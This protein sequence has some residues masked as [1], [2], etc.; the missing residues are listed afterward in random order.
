L[1]QLKIIRGQLFEEP[2]S[3]EAYFTT[4]YLR[5]RKAEG[6]I[7]S[8]CE[9]AELPHVPFA[10]PYSAEWKK[11]NYSCEK[12]LQYLVKHP[13]IRNILE[14]GCGNGWLTAKLSS[15]TKGSATGMDINRVELEQAKKV[16]GKL[17]GICFLEGDIRT[18]VLEEKRFDMIVFAASIQYFPSIKEIIESAL[19]HLT[20]MGEIHIIDS[21]F[22]RSTEL[23][24]AR[25]RSRNYFINRGIPEMINFYF[26]HNS[27]E[28]NCFDYQLL[29]N[30]D[31][32]LQKLKRN[33]S[34]F[35]WVVIKNYK[36]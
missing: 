10:H 33:K 18:G 35:P 13:H 23:P 5:L 21:H 27:N 14:V 3:E 9:V 36:Y 26:H 32:W 25:E 12:L 19:M 20:L 2:C 30:P 6:R 29:Y 15:V 4:L 7:Y 11:R 16:F 24:A 22:Y 8:N 31:S 28:L 34:P 17:P 1:Q